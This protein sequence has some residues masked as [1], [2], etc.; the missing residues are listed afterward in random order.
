MPNHQIYINFIT[1]HLEHAQHAICI[2]Q[3]FCGEC[4]ACTKWVDQMHPDWCCF[5]ADKMVGVED[6]NYLIH[7]SHFYPKFANHKLISI[8][9]P[10]GITEAAQNK[11]LKVLEESLQTQ[12]DIY[13]DES[14]QQLILP[15]L[16]SRLKVVH[17]SEKELNTSESELQQ[18]QSFIL[19]KQPTPPN[20]DINQ[21]AHALSH[22]I[23]KGLGD[24][25]KLIAMMDRVI[26]IKRHHSFNLKLR[27]TSAIQLIMEL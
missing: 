9:C 13:I 19:Q 8:I 2:N 10:H 27:A 22:L 16:Y 6:I 14:I 23:V 1:N 18:W 7:K 24:T 5:H 4:H 15:T 17:Q 21:L 26:K 11:L 12:W 25:S 20:E 3:S